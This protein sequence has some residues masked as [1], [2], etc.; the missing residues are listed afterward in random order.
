MLSFFLL[1]CC[2]FVS[3]PVLVQFVKIIVDERIACFLV[4][5]CLSSLLLLLA[6]CC[7]CLLFAVAVAVGCLQT[8]LTGTGPFY[9]Y[10]DISSFLSCL[11]LLSFANLGWYL[12]VFIHIHNKKSDPPAVRVS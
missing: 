8:L 5:A 12:F 9:C 4:V 10:S 1:C 3:K 6:C 2:C 11:L 7:C